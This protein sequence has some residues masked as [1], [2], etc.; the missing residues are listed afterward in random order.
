M[1]KRECGGFLCLNGKIE[2]NELTA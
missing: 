1:T 2:H